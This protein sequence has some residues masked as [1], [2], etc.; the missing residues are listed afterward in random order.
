MKIAPSYG[1]SAVLCW[2]M[3]TTKN[4][5]ASLLTATGKNLSSVITPI[6]W[7][8][9]KTLRG[10]P[11]LPNMTKQSERSEDDALWAEITKDIRK[12]P[13]SEQPPAKPVVLPEI[14][15][16]VNLAAA[17]RGEKLNSLD[18][19]NTADMDGSL[20]KRFKRCELPVEAT[21]DLHGFREEEAHNAV[22]GFIQKSYLA[23][24]RCIIIIT[25]K[26]LPHNGSCED[27][28]SPKGKLKES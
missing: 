26:G 10:K 8:I 14:R 18:V 17:Y 25:G 5:A 2:L 19:G 1:N 22:F 16:S 23:G 28:F 24:K 12:M 27:I 6:T 9:P 4:K 7:L 11:R 15:P 21:L 3:P 20:A 13:E